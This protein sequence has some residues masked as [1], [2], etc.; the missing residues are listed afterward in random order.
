ML[1]YTYGFYDCSSTL[2]KTNLA[3]KQATS[4]T[5]SSYS[6][7]VDFRW[8]ESQPGIIYISGGAYEFMGGCFNTVVKVSTF[9]DFAFTLMSPMQTARCSHESVVHQGFLYIISGYNHEG[10]LREC[11]RLSLSENC[12]ETLE[13][14]PQASANG[15]AIVLG[16]FLYFIG[17]KNEDEHYPIQRLNLV[18]LTWEVMAVPFPFSRS[19]IA[20]FKLHES[21]AFFI[22]EHTLYA[23]T[24]EST[25][26]DVVKTLE[27]NDY[28]AYWGPSYYSDGILFC[29]NSGPPRLY[30]IGPLAT[31]S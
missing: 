15:S 25:M 27:D 11:E 31:N 29:A 18:H 10:Y 5:C 12:W 4:I 16:S 13:P 28:V 21:K 7:E 24:P 19:Y 6:F 22:I 23:F 17:G 9:R 30:E 14:I 20:V 3:T 2:I 26:I 8:A 1:S